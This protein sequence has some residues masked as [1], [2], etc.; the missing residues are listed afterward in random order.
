MNENN[1]FAIRMMEARALKG[2]SQAEL[3]KIAGIA[4]ATISSYENGKSPTINKA[5][6]IVNALEVSLDWL[7]GK[8]IEETESEK[9]P[10]SKIAKALIFLM[11]I[12]GVS[13]SFSDDFNEQTRCRIDIANETISSFLFDYQRIQG[14][15]ED[16]SYTKY[17]K[18]S[19]VKTIIDKYSDFYGVSLGK[20]NIQCK[21]KCNY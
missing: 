3:S 19:L 13:C 9:V 20:R 7:C 12:Q 14:V 11:N 1:T 21:Y 17:L 16:S 5:L 6:K 18:Y 4:P 8:D 15:L 10:F 2:I